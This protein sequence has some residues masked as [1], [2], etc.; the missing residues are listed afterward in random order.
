MPKAFWT[1]KPPGSV[2]NQTK[3]GAVVSN[4]GNIVA[5]LRRSIPKY[6]ILASIER[7][8]ALA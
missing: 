6:D 8:S 4:F 3:A 5:I 2:Q 1:S 7:A